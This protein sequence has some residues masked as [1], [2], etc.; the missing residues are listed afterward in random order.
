[1]RRSW[2]RRWRARLPSLATVEQAQATIAV[3]NPATG[4]LVREVPLTADVGALV[5]RA[6]AVQPA[7]EALGYQGRARV[8]L[9]ARRWLI[10]HAEE[11]VATIVSETGKT[12]EDA[13]LVELA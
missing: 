8:L 3:E 13:R 12:D 9:R 6:R 4:E 7:W 1:M 11:V 5:E 2:R 10:E